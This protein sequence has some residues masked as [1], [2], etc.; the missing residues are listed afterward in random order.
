MRSFLPDENLSR[1]LAQSNPESRVFS[2]ASPGAESVYFSE[3][4]FFRGLVVLG[5]TSIGV[6]QPRASVST[7]YPPPRPIA[8]DPRPRRGL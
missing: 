4:L 8:Q 2:I 6:L 7:E 5:S 1:I 3:L